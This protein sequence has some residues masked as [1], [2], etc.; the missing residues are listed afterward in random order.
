M[1]RKNLFDGESYK[2]EFA[3]ITYRR[4]MSRQ[5]VTNADIMADRL[6]CTV[7]KL[8]AN[9]SNCDGYGELKKIVCVVKKAIR[10]KLGVRNK[11]VED[12]FEED[13]NNK[14]R[15]FRYIGKDNDP[16]AD[17]RNAKAINNLRQYWKFCQDSA[18]FFPKSWLEYF[19][20]DC[21][22]LLDMRAKHQKGEQV[23]SVS[24]DRILTNIEYLPPLY[25]AITNKLVLEIDYKPFD[26]EN[27][28][29]M[30]HPHYLKECNGRWHLFGHAEGREPGYGYNIALD[31]IQSKPRERS[32]V[33]Y[34][35]APKHF[36]DE[37]FKDIVGV[38]HVKDA[39]KEHIVIRARSLYIYKLMDTKP[40]H[41]SY[42]MVKPYAQYDD[43][44]Y[45]EFSVDVE[46]NNEFY[47]RIL[48]MGAGLEI[49]S[50][51]SVR[52]EFARRVHDLVDLYPKK[53]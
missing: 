15:R 11:S 49:V 9:L 32:M 23:I 29:L 37:F 27:V 22:D 38:S 50:P 2:A 53:E 14:N 30:F 18:G 13:G 16:L 46:P 10:E 45:A 21:Q 34:V 5:W 36:Y 52:D 51:N 42:T 40:L 39:K 24:L 1:I 31:R 8:P 7:E 43:G 3:I 35:P 19:F 48:Q 28:T 41:Q 6:G 17:M 33:E 47:G 12:C 20:K 44:E 25:E 4:L 26:E